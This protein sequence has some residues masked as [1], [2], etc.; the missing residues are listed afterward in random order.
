MLISLT[1]SN[2]ASFAQASGNDILF[3]DST[4]TNKIPHEIAQYVSSQ[5]K[6]VA[7]VQAPTL[8]YTA[9][10]VLY[11]YYGN[12]QATGQSNKSGVWDSHYVGVWH[13]V[14]TSGPHY[15]S[16]SNGNTSSAVSV[17]AQG[18]IPS[19]I[20][21]GDKLSAATDVVVIP[22]SASIGTLV[23]QQTMSAWIYGTGSWNFSLIGFWSNPYYSDY[24]AI[25][26][27]GDQ[28]VQWTNSLG[29][30]GIKGGSVSTGAWHYVVV[31]NSNTGTV[32][33]DGSA[34]GSG[35]GLSQYGGI[36][37]GIY[38][39]GDGVS[40]PLVGYL[41]EPRVS[42]IVRSAGWIGTEY[43]NQGSPGTFYS[44]GA[45]QT[46]GGGGAPVLSSITIDAPNAS[47]AAGATDQ[48]TATGTYS[49][50]ST[51]DVTSEVAWSSS[52][53]AVATIN[54][55]GLAT[56][57][58]AGSTTITAAMSGVTSNP[59]GLTVTSAMLV[60]I[61]IDAT[62]P[63]IAVGA[64][65]QFSATGTYSDSSTGNITSGVT[66]SSSNEAVATVNAGGLATAV[67]AGTTNISA[68]MNG[69]TS[70]LVMLTVTGST[71]REYI[72]LGGRAIAIENHD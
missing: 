64:T 10:T 51:Q 12:S 40:H 60:S 28:N 20:A 71:V 5:G 66:W 19:I 25:N 56:A 7:W 58:A 6:L 2:L 30:Y 48:F 49:D 54:A 15:D 39:G 4:G 42:N 3:T 13:L 31:T 29:S 23:N 41:V 34:G 69:V 61:A 72:R 47:M 24:L 53:T 21:G 22:P 68:S 27:W 70:G 46:S 26:F 37:S 17:T 33:V 43:R 36:S 18:S 50:G 65:D 59:A 8:S 52:N 14:E 11:L 35:A 1:D 44:I 32:Y 67:A 9:D 57:I 38:L 55:S 62:S 16:T 45:Q 63:S